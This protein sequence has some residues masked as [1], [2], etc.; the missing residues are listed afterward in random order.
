MKHGLRL[1]YLFCLASLVVMSSHANTPLPYKISGELIS[2]EPKA[3]EDVSDNELSD[4][5]SEPYEP[6]DLS[7]AVLTIS[8]R[9]G[10]TDGDEDLLL[11]E[12]VFHGS[13]ELASE[14]QKPTKVTIALKLSEETEPM[15]IEAVVGT[16]R[17]VH[18][19]YIDHPHTDDQF[20]L[21]GTYSH[22][23][24]AENRFSV[25]GDLSFLEGELTNDTT[26]YVVATT[27]NAN[28]ERQSTWW[29]PVLVEDKSFYIEG[30]VST[31]L[32][33]HL[34]VDGEDHYFRTEVILEPQGEIVVSELG[35]G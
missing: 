14:V 11:H 19:A 9:A 6:V 18:F 32:L 31:P 8:Y 10:N 24:N 30:D 26:A 25:E 5:E 35:N 1:F 15:K 20:I 33:G 3:I 7:D 13:F 28:G 21:V 34:Y 16:G 17:D 27:F 29:G 4:T 12:E 23:L 22:V 2:I